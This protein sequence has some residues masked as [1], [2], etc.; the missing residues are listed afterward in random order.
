MG[1]IFVFGLGFCCIWLY[2]QFIGVPIVNNTIYYANITSVS[3]H[4]NNVIIEKIN[5]GNN[6]YKFK[7]DRDGD[8]STTDDMVR[9]SVSS[10]KY[11]K[12]SVG[13]TVIE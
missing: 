8:I 1:K 10:E 6:N 3:K 9:I 13:D 5:D 11:H 4:P 12:Y 2:L 7:I